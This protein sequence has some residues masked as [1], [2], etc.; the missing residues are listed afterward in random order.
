MKSFQEAYS[1]IVH[2]RSYLF[3]IPLGASG[4]KFVEETTRLATAFAE[5]SALESVALQALMVMPALL[6][7]D[8]G[9][10]LNHRQRADG[11]ERRLRLWSDGNIEELLL[12]G[13]VIQ[14]QLEARMARREKHKE[15]TTAKTFHR[16]M[17]QGKVKSAI[18]L[19]SE[20]RRGQLLSLD[21]MVPDNDGE[22]SISVRETL[23]RKHP[24]GVP[25]AIDALLQEEPPETHPVLFDSLNGDKIRQAAIHTQGS[26]GPSGLDAPNWRRLCTMYHGA[27]KRLCASLA[28]V[29]RRLCTLFV[30]PAL[31]HPLI[32]CR[33]I[34]LSKNPGVRPIGVCETLRR[35]IGE[36]IMKVVGPE[37]QRVAGTSQLCA[38][39]KSGCEAAVHAMQQ[40]FDGDGGAVLL[41][42][43]SNAF[44]SLNREAM[45]H[46]LQVICPAF[47]T[48]VINY[49]RAPAAL[50][51]GGDS[52][53][54]TESTT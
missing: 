6:L 3:T 16:L 39:Q 7:Q 20:P 54:S 47:A 25:A 2:W 29:A 8:P 44:N 31:I 35:I 45:L 34:P 23:E 22:S 38:G 24:P 12:E 10:S 50:F 17:V 26:A 49:Y 32:A 21:Q 9:G 40:L 30:D 36:A 4:K 52:I 11:L 18:R 27:S 41:V 19:L 1:T 43:A 13:R 15:D 48:C 42:D 53:L 5:R 46:N 28:G 51:V 33:L 37:I 14:R